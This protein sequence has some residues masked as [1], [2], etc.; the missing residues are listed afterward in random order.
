MKANTVITRLDFLVVESL[1]KKALLDNWVLRSHNFTIQQ[2]SYLKKILSLS[3]SLGK[4]QVIIKL[5]NPV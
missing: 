5:L 3:H 2:F 1:V 4:Y